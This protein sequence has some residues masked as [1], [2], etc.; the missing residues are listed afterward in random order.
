MIREIR[1]SPNQWRIS[2]YENNRQDWN[3]DKTNLS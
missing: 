3:Q 2:G 1:I